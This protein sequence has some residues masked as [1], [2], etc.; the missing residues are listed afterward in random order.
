MTAD[1]EVMGDREEKQEQQQK[2][3]NDCQENYCSVHLLL[4]TYVVLEWKVKSRTRS[5]R[6]ETDRQHGN[7]A[8]GSNTVAICVLLSRT[9]RYDG[10]IE[11]G[12]S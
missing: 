8:V 4:M 10:M 1:R 6:K 12:S 5:A 7:D 2:I 11:N 3:I 9:Y